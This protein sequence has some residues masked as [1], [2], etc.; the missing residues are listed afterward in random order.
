[1]DLGV[2]LI[3]SGFMGKSHALAY[4]A[5]RAAFG[6]VPAPRLEI[7]CDRPLERAEIFAS[8]FG[9]SRATDDWRAAV[10]DPAIDI[11]S[12]TTPND[13][14]HDMVLAAAAAGKHIW[15]EKPLGLTLEDGERME[16]AVREAGVHSMIG[17]N[18]THNPTIQH[19]KRLIAEGEIGR[20]T[21][22]RGFVDEDY[23]ADPETP[24]S[25]RCLRSR[26]GLGALGDLGC[27]LVSLAY[28]LVGP[29]ESVLADMQTVHTDR[30]KRDGGRG[31]VE[32]EDLASALVRFRDGFQGVL[33]TTRI[34]WGRKNKLAVEVHGEKGT[35]CF[36]QERLNELQLFRNEGHTA[37]QGFRTILAGPSHPPY[38]A[39]IPG[40]GHSLGF[41]DQKTI[42]LAAFL[43]TITGGAKSGPD[44]TE[45]L[46]YEKVI[47]GIAR[48]AETGARVVI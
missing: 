36:D 25:W 43:R 33:C 27:H 28:V 12:V 11:V 8:Q 10:A 47:H 5:V 16:R 41:N 7:M 9:F 6:D 31:P 30:P 20:V 19:A 18:Y 48:S 17:Y 29:I 34:A 4:R 32:N 23:Q 22:F 35:L 45:A 40:A 21:H 38:G 14:H 37:V 44:I 2:A 3:G 13:L 24:W 46:E 15:C 1:M 39:F 42:E 26:G